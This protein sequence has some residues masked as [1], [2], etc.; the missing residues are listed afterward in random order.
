MASSS[1]HHP[2]KQHRSYSPKWRTEHCDFVWISG[3]STRGLS[4]NGTPYHWY[5]RCSRDCAELGSSLNWTSGMP[6]I[7]SESRKATSTMPHSEPTTANW[8]TEL[9]PLAW[10]VHWRPFS[11]PLLT[12][13]GT[14]LTTSPCVTS[15]SYILLDQ[16]DGAW[17]SRTESAA[18]GKGIQSVLHSRDV[19]IRCLGSR[20]PEVN[21]QL[22]WDRHVIR[23]HID[24]RGLAYTKVDSGCTGATRIHKLH[25][26]FIRKYA[27]NTLPLTELLKRT[28]ITL[29]TRPKSALKAE[30]KPTTKWEW[31][32]EAELAFQKLKK[33]FTGAP[34]LQHFHPAKA[35][36]LQTDASGFTIAGILN[37]HDSFEILRPLNFHSR[38]CTPAEQT[39]DTYDREL[40]AI[41]ETMGQ[42]R[43]YL[44]EANYK[45]LIQCA[46]RNLEYFQTSIV[47]S[48]RP[49]R[50]AEIFSS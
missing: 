13:Y 35:T 7:S 1:S 11:L 6:V 36:L 10:Q 5:R 2:R 14:I 31:T 41:V 28:E 33:A 8:N 21:H 47:L 24:N 42:W 32:R 30:L 44:Q 17:R 39:Y 46:H 45:I 40:L 26:R 48:R 25:W 50:W 18:K 29:E 4:K 22:R 19:P 38:K 43:H 23:S 37:H 49:A 20:L 9:C 15:T 16:W 12:A 27:K 34:I 3:I